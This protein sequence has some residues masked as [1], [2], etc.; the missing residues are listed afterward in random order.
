MTDLG[1]SVEWPAT[2]PPAIKQGVSYMKK[3]HSS[4][5]ASKLQAQ[6]TP[7]QIK[8]IKLKVNIPDKVFPPIDLCISPDVLKSLIL[9][10]YPVHNPY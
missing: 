2:Y 4:W 10:P 6:F 3:I 9:N 7:K 1:Y 5:R 8:M